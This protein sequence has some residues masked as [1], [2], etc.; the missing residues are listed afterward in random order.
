MILPVLTV[1]EYDG[2]PYFTMKLCRGSL[3][4]RVAEYRGRGREA[5]EL[6]AE[7]AGAVHHAHVRGVLHRDLKPGNVLFDEAKRPFIGDFGLA[8]LL[9][10]PALGAVTRPLVVMGTPGYLAPEVRAWG[11]RRPRWT[12]SRSGRSCTSC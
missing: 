2:L 5:A 12:C 9:D 1:G 11:R 4:E 6:V 3:A 7:L 10:A 8:K